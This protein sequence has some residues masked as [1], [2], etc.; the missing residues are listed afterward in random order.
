M[1]SKKLF[2]NYT[3]KVDTNQTPIRIDK[4][5]FDKMPNVTRNKI[6]EGIKQGVVKV[7]GNKVKPSYKVKPSDEVTASLSKERKDNNIKPE[8]I[9]LNIVYEDK[10]LLVINKPSGMV[11]H[12]AYENWEGTLVNALVYHFRN[13]PQMKNNEGRPGLVHR[14]DKET[15]GLLVIAKTENA[16]ASLSSQFSDHSI[17]RKYQAL[18]W[19]VP[20]EREGTIDINLRRSLK[21]RRIIEGYP[22]NT[23]GKKAITHYKILE[24]IHYL[25]L[26]EC[27]LETG[28]THQ[29]R[30]HMKHIGH[31]IFCD[32]TYGG[33]LIVKGN[34]FSNYKK[35]VENSF[36]IINRQA[37]HAKS[38]GFIH[39]K[40]KKEVFFDSDL[41]KDIRAVIEKWK[42]YELPENY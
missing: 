16:M 6:K 34:K 20:K 26:I 4:F 41:P 21:D 32:K 35:F 12:P 42:K 37:L 14:I 39:P 40:T 24:T 36:K 22:E 27:E 13:L 15:S 9:K 8:N 25:S 18:I 5:L 10:E 33:N 1:E 7:N 31:P 23:I 3:F 17:K 19:G 2:E 38:L 11:V 28:R 29:I 30:A